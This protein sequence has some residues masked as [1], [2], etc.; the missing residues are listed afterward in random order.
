MFCQWNVPKE[1]QRQVMFVHT[2]WF[3][4]YLS[5]NIF[6]ATPSHF[7]YV[8]TDFNGECFL[9]WKSWLCWH[10]FNQWNVPKEHHR[11]FMSVQATQFNFCPS[12]NILMG[13]AGL[14]SFIWSLQSWTGTWMDTDICVRWQ[15]CAFVLIRDDVSCLLKRT[16]IQRV[17]GHVR[18][19][20]QSC[21]SRFVKHCAHMILNVGAWSKISFILTFFNG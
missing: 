8:L 4:F 6:P 16:V 5:M 9:A 11:Q 10:V 21:G 1:H 15:S 12:M 7:S 19:F 14:N 3:N 13:G 2:T 20:N 18:K 17:C